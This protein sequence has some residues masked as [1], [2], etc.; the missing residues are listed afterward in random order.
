MYIS[1]ESVPTGSLACA[2]ACG[3]VTGHHQKQ[4][5]GRHF[6]IDVH[7]Q[8]FAQVF[9]LQDPISGAARI[10]LLTDLLEFS[11]Q[12]F[13]NQLSRLNSQRQHPRIANQRLEHVEPFFKLFFV[14]RFVKLFRRTQQLARSSLTA[15]AFSTFSIAFRCD[16]NVTR[17]P[18][19]RSTN[20]S[21]RGSCSQAVQSWC[22]PDCS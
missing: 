21:A 12:I 2:S 6:A 9:N 3:N 4:R 7:D 19:K 14:L 17:S 13:I 22:Q 5:I 20:A 16:V 8:L 15:R 11:R 10:E 18:D 1:A